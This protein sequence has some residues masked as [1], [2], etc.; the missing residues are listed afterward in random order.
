MQELEKNDIQNLSEIVEKF[1][2]NDIKQIFGGKSVK[3]TK[4]PEDVNINLA[5]AE[6]QTQASDN[7]S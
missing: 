5:L 6:R 4:S 2:E 7:L 1:D 3:K